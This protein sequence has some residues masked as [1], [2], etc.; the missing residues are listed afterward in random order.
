MDIA[1]PFAIDLIS[2]QD[3]SPAMKKRIELDGEL[4]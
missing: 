1:S 2:L 3:V 4:I